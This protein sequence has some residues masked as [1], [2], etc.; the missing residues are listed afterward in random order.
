MF[1]IYFFKRFS[2]TIPGRVP[3]RSSQLFPAS[4]YGQFLHTAFAH[5][6]DKDWVLLVNHEPQT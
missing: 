6:V 3:H 2:G 5:D 4:R 1:D